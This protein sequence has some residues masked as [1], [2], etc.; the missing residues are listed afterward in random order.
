MGYSF[1]DYD[2]DIGETPDYPEHQTGNFVYPVIGL[3]GEIGEFSEKINALSIHSSKVSEYIQ[4]L[5][6]NHSLSG[7]TLAYRQA[8]STS[9]IFNEEGEKINALRLGAIKELGDI[10]WYLN[11][12]SKQLG[13]HL[14]EVAQLNVEKLLDRRARGVIK[15][16]GDNR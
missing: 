3:V 2:N 8:L 1:K 10:L 5:W 7:F 6:R 12:L 11:D 16:E 13:I 9:D 14:E 15:S 4:K